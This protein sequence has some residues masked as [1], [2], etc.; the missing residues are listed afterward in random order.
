MPLRG[1]APQRTQ[2]PAVLLVQCDRCVRRHRTLPVRLRR[3]QAGDGALGTDAETVRPP[4]LPMTSEV[5]DA[6]TQASDY[7]MRMRGE[8]ADG[9]V[10]GQRGYRMIVGLA[11]GGASM[12]KFLRAVVV[13]LA[14]VAVGV[15]TNQV[16]NAGKWNLSWLVGA[17][18]L[19][20]SAEGINLW[21][22]AR[23]KGGPGDAGAA[24]GEKAGGSRRLLVQKARGGRDVY[25]A[26]RHMT[27]R[28]RHGDE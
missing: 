6:T 11:V 18:L 24:G 13:G 14:A 17:V 28:Q 1:S 15:A 7:R 21:L 19:A 23:D 8:E 25:Q 20:A 16:L 9:I 5:V 22:E 10:S 2:G 4:S 26:G 27:I 3:G 12:R